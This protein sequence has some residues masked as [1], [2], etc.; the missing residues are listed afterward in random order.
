MTLQQPERGG[1]WKDYLVDGKPLT[2]PTDIDTL[3]NNRI[4]LNTG[5]SLLNI[6][7]APPA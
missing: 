4:A 3:P 6:A 2:S 5:R 1:E 7:S